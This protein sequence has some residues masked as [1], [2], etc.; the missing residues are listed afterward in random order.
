M[1]FTCSFSISFFIILLLS[2]LCHSI[3]FVSFSRPR[4]EVVL[5]GGDYCHRYLSHAIHLQ[6]LGLC[7]A[8]LVID[9]CLVSLVDSSSIDVLSSSTSLL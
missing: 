9:W 5:M 2:G 6:F 3:F 1:M 7:C 8:V 4:S